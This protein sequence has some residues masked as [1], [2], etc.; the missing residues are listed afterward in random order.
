MGS[1]AGEHGQ[2]SLFD[3]I[4]LKDK[5]RDYGRKKSVFPTLI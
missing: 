3:I 4:F 5:V 2:K 1:F